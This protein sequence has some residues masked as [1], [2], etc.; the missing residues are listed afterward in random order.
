[1]PAAEDVLRNSLCWEERAKHA[2]LEVFGAS[3]TGRHRYTFYATHADYFF[4]LQ[5]LFILQ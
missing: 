4:F 3:E 2:G 5:A 1:M